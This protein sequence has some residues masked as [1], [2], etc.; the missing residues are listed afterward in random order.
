MVTQ[1][2]TAL[3]LNGNLVIPPRKIVKIYEIF[4]FIE[5]GKRERKEMM[6]TGNLHTPTGP[7]CMDYSDKAK[8]G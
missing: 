6:T 8:N 3:S 1:V 4:V 2:Y 5:K 7:N